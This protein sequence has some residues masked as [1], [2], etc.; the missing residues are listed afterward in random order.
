MKLYLY[1]LIFAF[2]PLSL[3]SQNYTSY[4]I[5]DTADVVVNP[6]G[7]VCLM[8]GATEDDNAIKWFLHKANGGDVLVLR[9]SG[10]DGY[11]DYF[12]S[13]LGVAVNSVESIVCNNDSA[14][15]EPYLLRKIQQAEAIW[16]AG[17]DQWEYISFWRNSPV[18]SL[19]NQLILQRN[20]VIGGTSAGMAI[21]GK[22]YFSAQNGTVT[23][24]SALS[25]PFDNLVTVDSM[26]FLKHGY[27]SNVITDTH[28]DNP[29]RKG[30]IVVFLSRIFT[31]FGVSAKAI[32]CD[33]YTAVCVDTN[34]IASVF[35]G[36][37]T[38]DDNAY[39]IQL[40]C[41]LPSLTPEMCANNTPLTWNLESKALKVCKISGNSTGS[42]FL[43]LNNW[44]SG[45]GGQWFDWS[46]NNGAFLEQPGNSINC[47][48]LSVAENSSVE[49]SV[50]PN[51]TKENVVIYCSDQNFINA[52]IKLYTTLGMQVNVPYVK[53]QDN[54]FQFDLSSFPSGMY[55]LTVQ[56]LNGITTN[57][58]IIKN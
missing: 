5:G 55:F 58:I 33:E 22:Y 3:M 12:Y 9:T 13:Q 54:S 8:G 51:P 11:N 46:V 39:F 6:L 49:V 26:S 28:F 48:L 27:L 56:M 24:A 1:A 57:K 42:N 38:Y 53:T 10:S 30:R 34:G 15:S 7:G 17:G 52:Q 50:F 43:D 23:T 25:N 16:F 44:S 47:N 35:G 20:I 29:D 45:I 2:F 31:D 14:S 36:F 21:Q 41:E 32:A 19:I 4:F 40:N 18:D 37:P